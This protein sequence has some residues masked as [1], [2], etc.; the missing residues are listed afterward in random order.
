[1]SDFDYDVPES[2][3]HPALP[4]AGTG[5]L[6]ISAY[7]DWVEGTEAAD[8]GA[9]RDYYNRAAR[10]A[11]DN[12]LGDWRDAND[13]LQGDNPYA[14][15]GLIDDDTQE[16]ISWE[17]TTLIEEWLAGTYPNKGFFLRGISGAGPFKF[18]SREHADPGQRPILE[19][20]TSTGD[21]LID[22]SADVYLDPSTYQGLGDVDRLEISTEK[23]TLLRFDL[24]AVPE[25]AVIIRHPCASSFMQNMVGDPWRSVYSGAHRDTSSPLK[26]LCTDC[27]QIIHLDDG[28]ESDPAV[29]LFSNFEIGGLGGF[30]DLWN[31]CRY[32]GG[33]HYPIL[34]ACLHPSKAKPFV[35]R[36]RPVRIPE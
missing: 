6:S 22:P 16:Y 28:I 19:I 31:G 15:T 30:L 33:R 7:S 21:Y 34:A 9:T 10:L 4:D 11:W 8:D 3:P 23:P 27:L 12:A 2:G 24:S 20:H 29:Y 18:Y 35:P 36:S 25:S 1:M 17:V 14:V 5:N 13:Q 26:R 32:V